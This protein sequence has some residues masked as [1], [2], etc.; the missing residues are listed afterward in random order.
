MKL[1]SKLNVYEFNTQIVPDEDH[2]LSEAVW[3]KV[4]GLTDICQIYKELYVQ[5]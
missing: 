5:A 2:L 3:L 1:Q 4:K